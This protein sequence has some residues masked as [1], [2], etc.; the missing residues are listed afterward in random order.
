MARPQRGYPAQHFLR[1]RELLCS[2]LGHR[3]LAYLYI[4]HLYV[5]LAQLA[6]IPCDEG[7]ANESHIN[8]QL[9]LLVLSLYYCTVV[10]PTW[11]DMYFEVCA[12][13]LF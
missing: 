10:V 4:D 1:R 13:L 5:A 6:D 12:H 9:L 3:S 11:Y 2:L 8:Y 7:G